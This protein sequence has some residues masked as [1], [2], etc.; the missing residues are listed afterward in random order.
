MIELL[1]QI[2]LVALIAIIQF[3]A[4]RAKGREQAEAEAEHQPLPAPAP[5]Y[6]PP[7]A[8]P[9]DRAA[10]LD[11]LDALETEASALREQVRRDRL[12]DELGPV[13]DDAVLARARRLRSELASGDGPVAPWNAEILAELELIQHWIERFVL[14]RRDPRRRGELGDADALARACY[15]PLIEF[16][17]AN[18]VPL[19]SSVPVTFLGDFELSTWTGFLPTGAAPIFLPPDFF[20]RLAWWPALAHEIG[21][22]FV[23]ATEGAEDRM[24]AQLGLVSEEAGRRPIDASQGLHAHEVHRLY[25][26]WFEEMFCDLVG[27]LMLGP[28]YGETMVE[29]FAAPGPG[30][31]LQVARVQVDPYGYRY[32][33]HPPRHLRVLWCARVLELCGEDE[34]AEAVRDRW[35]ARHEPIEAIDLPTTVGLVGVPVDPLYQM[36]AEI[37][38]R[39]YREPQD[40]FDGHPVSAIP[41]A[42]W[43]P[44][45]AAEARRARADLEAGRPPTSARPRAIIAGAVLAWRQDP[46]R[47]EWLM[48]A[49]RTAIVGDAEWVDGAQP[50]PARPARPAPAAGSAAYLREAFVLHTIL[51]SPVALRSIRPRGL[52]ERRSRPAAPMPRPPQPRP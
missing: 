27:T 6:L 14:Q 32:G 52:V 30:G 15:R 43:G 25:A 7:D 29:L 26:A 24:R 51:G 49:A 8:L 12:S 34:A 31:A 38:E 1:A 45:M 40:A 36:G 2:A 35:T 13:L 11:R 47:E 39:L 23:A 41:G 46:A 28:A 48:A 9:E 22:D 44:W 21:H 17:H 10:I 3:I 37:L 16:A 4:R 42:D 33:V 19:T 50:T 18:R 20:R 5:V